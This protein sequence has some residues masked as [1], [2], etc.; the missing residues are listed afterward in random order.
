MFVLRGTRILNG[1]TDGEQPATF[2]LRF[3][4]CQVGFEVFRTQRHRSS[5]GKS[6]KLFLNKRQIYLGTS[7]AY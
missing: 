1:A 7:T 4:Y 2:N 5:N 3:M 6:S